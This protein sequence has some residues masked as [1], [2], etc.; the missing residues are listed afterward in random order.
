MVLV[1]INNI[2]IF[3]N[4][5]MRYN[6]LSSLPDTFKNLEKLIYLYFSFF[7]IINFQLLNTITK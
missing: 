1:L 4:S 5:E 6:A 7:M 2:K 3:F